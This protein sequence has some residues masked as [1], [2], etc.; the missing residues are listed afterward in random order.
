MKKYYLV[1]F[2]IAVI[3]PG[4][5]VAQEV[6]IDMSYDRYRNKLTLVLTN[7]SDKEL[8]VRN[9]SSLDEWS[10]SLVEMFYETK[11]GDSMHTPFSLF[12]YDMMNRKPVVLKVL[13]PYGKLERTFDFSL[14]FVHVLKKANVCL[15]MLCKKEGKIEHL[16]HFRKK[17]LCFDEQSCF[18][19]RRNAAPAS[20]SAGMFPS[21][22]PGGCV[23][24]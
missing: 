17:S 9:Q 5:G 8:W 6:G 3:I 14:T 1:V 11:D 15:T 18:A 19:E 4:Y 23:E 16:F 22:C 12:E 21:G 10:G 20:L 13:P 7:K 2:L 24:V